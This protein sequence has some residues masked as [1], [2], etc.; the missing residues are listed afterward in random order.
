MWQLI[1]M[2]T[3]RG[4][5]VN[6]FQKS[7]DSEVQFGLIWKSCYKN[8]HTNVPEGCALH[9]HGSQKS[10][11]ALLLG[12]SDSLI[13]PLDSSHRISSSLQ[14]IQPLRSSRSNIDFNEDIFR[15][16]GGGAVTEI[17]S[18]TLKFGLPFTVGR[19]YIRTGSLQTLLNAGCPTWLIF[20]QWNV[21]GNVVYHFWAWVFEKCLCQLPD[22]SWCLALSLC[23]H[24]AYSFHHVFLAS[25][26]HLIVY[27]IY[28][29]G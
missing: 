17:S 2:E 14:R 6:H 26:L 20:C 24:V 15:R 25:L 4:G 22:L 21:H 16:N 5:P 29:T 3:W 23:G 8:V 27:F 1:Y 10:A 18:Y 9:V 13:F 11:V 19:S 7:P 12:P 28:E